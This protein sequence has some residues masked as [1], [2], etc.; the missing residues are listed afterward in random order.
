MT[1]IAS[2]LFA[3][4]LAGSIGAIISTLRSSISRISEVIELEF[5]PASPNQRRISFGEIKGRTP[6]RVAE[7]IVF[8]RKQTTDLDYRLAA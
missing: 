1:L 3:I 4:A 8:P 5:A 6:V 7:V 2:L